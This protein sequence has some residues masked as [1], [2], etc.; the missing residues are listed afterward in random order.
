MLARVKSLFP[1]KARRTAIFVVALPIMGGMMSQNILNLVDIAMVGRLGDAALAATGIGSFSNYLAISFIIG[2]SAGVQALAAR[3]LGEE[4]HSETA[5]PLNG[6]LALALMIGIPLCVILWFATPWAFG[7]LTS[8]PEVA[9]LGI[10]YLQVR[11][12]SM[13]A[14]GMNFSFR[15]Y[16]SAIH[17]T[18]IYLRTLLIMHAINIF[19]NWVLIFG[20][21]GAPE[22]G[23]F[24]AGLGT[25]ISL[26]IGTG[27]YFFFAIRHASDKGFLQQRPTLDM[28]WRQFRLSLPSSIQQLFFSAGLVT[29]VWIVGK[30]GTAEVAAI[31]VLMTFHI[32]AILPAFG[33]ALATLTLVGN[34]LG[35]NDPDDAETWGWN[36]AALTFVYGLVLSIILVPLAMPILGLFLTNPDTQRLAYLPMV[37]WA[38]MIAFDTLGM[39]LMNALIGA[40]DTRRS[41]WI[42]VVAQWVF[43]LPAAYVVGPVLGF[44]LLGVWVINGIYRVGQA[45]VCAH[46]WRGRKWAGIEI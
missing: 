9:E 33:I 18:G 29:L 45:L 7:F 10:P 16:W 41:M 12:L 30:I 32:T 38:I 43:F 5:V 13:M 34:A 31:N 17:M 1:D 24:G 37:L 46:Q 19:L 35:R 6:G 44:G 25:T 2:L 20:N 3:R 42:S 36:G 23:V 8:D 14:V 22:L 27:L 40:G 21:L 26:Y 11:V 28:L 4:R 15:G 39:V